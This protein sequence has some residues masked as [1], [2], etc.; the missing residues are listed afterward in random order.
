MQGV[1]A[2]RLEVDSI[3][4]VARDGVACQGIVARRGDLDSNFAPRDGVAFQGVLVGKEEADALRGV[5]RGGVALQ[6]VVVG[7]LKVDSIIKALNSEIL[8][9]NP[10]FVIK[11]NS[12]S[13]AGSGYRISGPIQGQVVLLYH[14]PLG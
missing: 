14:Y 2:G 5:P 1:L 13:R 10:G 7:I 6:G 12:I 11:V 9:G 4:G 3:I 8:D